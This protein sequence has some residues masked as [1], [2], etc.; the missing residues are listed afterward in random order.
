[1][2]AFPAI[3]VIDLQRS[4]VIFCQLI[5]YSLRSSRIQAFTRPMDSRRPMIAKR[6]D[7][8]R[9]DPVLEGVRFS[10]LW[11][12]SRKPPQARQQRPNC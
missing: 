12:S 7:L 4:K 8:N 10:R 1:M 6:A 2:H 3:R 11:V 9:S 5:R